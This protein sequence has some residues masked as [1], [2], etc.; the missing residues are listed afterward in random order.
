MI[1]LRAET[2]STSHPLPSSTPP[3]GTPPLLPIPLRTPSP[4]FL[5]PSTICRAGVLEVTLSPRKMLCIALGMRYEVGE[6]SFAPTA[7]HSRGFREDY[8]FVATLDDEIRRD[9]ERDV[10]YGITDTFFG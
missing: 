3:S 5:L 2:P 6:S 7:R 9:P 8:G 10:G 1:Q 4:P